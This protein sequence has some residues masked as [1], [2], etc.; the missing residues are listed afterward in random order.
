MKKRFPTKASEN[1][2]VRFRNWQLIPNFFIALLQILGRY[3]TK[4][5]VA[6]VCALL[7]NGK[8]GA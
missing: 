3:K 1:I 7:R 2:T 5:A 6:A 4:G 8:L